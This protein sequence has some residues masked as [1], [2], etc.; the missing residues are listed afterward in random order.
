[1]KRSLLHSRYSFLGLLI[2]AL[3]AIGLV[4]IFSPVQTA[5]ADTASG[6]LA[7]KPDNS[8]CLACHS[9]PGQSFKLPNS[10]LLGTTIDPAL[11]DKSTHSNLDC[12]L[13]HVNISSYPH[14][15]NAAQSARDYTMEY[16]DTCKQCHADQSKKVAD[17]IHTKMLNNNN[18]N[19][20][21][22]SDC[23]NPH[24]QPPVKKDVNG[25]PA[26][27]EHANIAKICSKCHNTIY[28]QYLTSVHGSGIADNKNPDVPACTNCH[29]VHSVQGPDSPGFTLNSPTQVCGKCHSDPKIMNK[30]GISTDVMNTYVADFHGTTVTLFQ[31]IDPLA[32]TN[33]PVC[34]DCHGVHDIQRTDDPTK[35]IALKQNMLGACQ[36]CHPDAT[37]NFPDSWLSHYI[38]SPDKAPLVF[39]VNVF[40]N[41][42]IPAVLGFM[43]LIIL[44]DLYRRLVINRRPGAAAHAGPAGK[45]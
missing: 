2:V 7:Q 35:G 44:T 17:S 14:P 37:D 23:H 11:F 36:R 9:Q 3:I 1:M 45:K 26:P 28:E 29:G 21:I 6:P 18:L 22:C 24:S 16:K 19:A 38:P 27:S 43:V 30:Y 20:P 5:S 4:L 12:K 13:C 33:K 40:Y 32:K 10:E 39:W 31:K 8:A 42:L 34:Y 25:N 41:I 15:K